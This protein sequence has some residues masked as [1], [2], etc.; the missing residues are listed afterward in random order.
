RAAAYQYA[1]G[2]EVGLT[3]S[4]TTLWRFNTLSNRATNTAAGYNNQV[5]SLLGEESKGYSSNGGYWIFSILGQTGSSVFTADGF[6]LYYFPEGTALGKPMILITWKIDRLNVPEGSNR[7]TFE[8]ALKQSGS[9]N[10]NAD[11][12]VYHLVIDAPV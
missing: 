3:P 7:V 5:F 2:G 9:Y 6:V 10:Q 11:Y 12:E 8:T 4:G 1:Q